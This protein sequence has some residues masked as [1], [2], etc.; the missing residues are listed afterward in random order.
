MQRQ[1]SIRQASRPGP[2]HPQGSFSE[3]ASCDF[4]PFQHH[5]QHHTEVSILGICLTSNHQPR[6]PNPTETLIPHMNDIH[7]YMA[8]NITRPVMS[9]SK[10]LLQKPCLPLLHKDTCLCTP[11]NASRHRGTAVCNH[12]ASCGTPSRPRSKC[13]RSTLC[14]SYEHPRA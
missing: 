2:R 6:S 3:T 7:P 9:L 13:H 4:V 14:Q 5:H 1:T 10:S 8:C 12:H 11:R